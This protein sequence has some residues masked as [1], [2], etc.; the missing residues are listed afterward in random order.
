MGPSGTLSRTEGRVERL[1]ISTGP[2]KVLLS[3]AARGSLPLSSVPRPSPT[4]PQWFGECSLVRWAGV[5]V[6]TRRVAAGHGPSVLSCTEV[7]Q[8]VP[9]LLLRAALLAVLTGWVLRAGAPC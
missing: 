8:G 3:A 1:R 5:E 7:P 4:A 9:A 6:Q 2:S